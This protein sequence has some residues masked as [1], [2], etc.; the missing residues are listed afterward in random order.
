VGPQ[1]AH[2]WKSVKEILMPGAAPELRHH[3]ELVEKLLELKLLD[4]EWPE[5]KARRSWTPQGSPAF[6][7][8]I[9]AAERFYTAAEARNGAMSDN[10][11]AR[12]RGAS[13]PVVLVTGG[14]HSASIAHAL[15]TQGIGF[16]VVTPVVE[17]LDQEELYIRSMTE[18]PHET[19]RAFILSGN[20]TV[21][22][23]KDL[24]VQIG[25]RARIPWVVLRSKTRNK[26]YRVAS[27]GP[28]KPTTNWWW[29]WTW[30]LGP[31]LASAAVTLLAIMGNATRAAAQTL[32]PANLAPGG[33]ATTAAQHL[34]VYTVKSGDSLWKIAGAHWP[35]VQS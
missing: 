26:V 15:K 18:P 13:G 27:P 19:V 33:I 14:F 20:A 3:L 35:I 32:N 22:S 25:E 23:L 7:Q 11:L 30:K 2:E 29:D 28:V 12:V 31:V 8:A 16:A 17:R 24:L 5:Y 6:R 10:L 9:L 34:T 4:H 21:S 1:A